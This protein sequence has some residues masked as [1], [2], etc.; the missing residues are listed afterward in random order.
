MIIFEEFNSTCLFKVSKHCHYYSTPVL[1]SHNHC[2]RVKSEDAFQ[3]RLE[4]ETR[5]SKPSSFTIEDF[6]K[7]TFR[8]PVVHDKAFNEWLTIIDSS[9]FKFTKQ[10]EIDDLVIKKLKEKNSKKK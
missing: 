1:Y 6:D 8:R 3:K 7:R 10:K 9:L 5:D 2:P 4:L